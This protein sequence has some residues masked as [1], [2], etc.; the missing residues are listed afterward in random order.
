MHT[1][2]EEDAYF[3]GR[4]CILLG[5]RIREEGFDKL[6]QASGGFKGA[7]KLLKSLKPLKPL[8]N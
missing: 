8:K 3:W 1:F 4:G 5:K 6:S 7:L 2:G